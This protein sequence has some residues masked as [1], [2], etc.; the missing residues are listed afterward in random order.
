MSHALWGSSRLAATKKRRK[1]EEEE[2]KREKQM[3][4]EGEVKGQR[5][6]SRRWA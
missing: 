2:E 5:V 4:E 1:A 3:E 6:D